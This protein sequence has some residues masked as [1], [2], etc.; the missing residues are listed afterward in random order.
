MAISRSFG[1]H[2][3]EEMFVTHDLLQAHLANHVTVIKKNEPMVETLSV[4]LPQIVKKDPT[5]ITLG[6]VYE[7]NCPNCLGSITTLEMDVDKKHFCIAHCIK[8]N[9]QLETREVAKL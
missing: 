4:V 6:Y 5:P 2:K 8:C 3:C 7:G 9:K 1:C